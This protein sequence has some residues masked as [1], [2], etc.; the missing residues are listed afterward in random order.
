MTNE[1]GE[2]VRGSDGKRIEQKLAAGESAQKIAARLTLRIFNSRYDG[3]AD[4]HRP[5]E[6]LKYEK[7]V[8]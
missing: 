7:W 1:H 2:P 6:R 5:T 8:Y 3:M 4:F